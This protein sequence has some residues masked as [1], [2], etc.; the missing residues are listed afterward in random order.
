MSP[1][2]FGRSVAAVIRRW[3]RGPRGRR[4]GHTKLTDAQQRKVARLIV[5]NKPDRLKLPG[6]FWT[7]AA[8]RVVD[9]DYAQLER[10]LIAAEKRIAGNPSDEAIAVLESWR[11]RRAVSTHIA[12][13][14]ALWV[15]Y[16]LISLLV[17]FLA[18]G[19]ASLIIVG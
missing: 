12:E 14:K 5:G 10:R 15:S 6:C 9:R 18:A 19:V 17:A 13:G 1:T 4:G 3:R 16:S 7:R 11:A 8:A 2:E